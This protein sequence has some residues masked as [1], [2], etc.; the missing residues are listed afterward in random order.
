LARALASGGSSRCAQDP[1]GRAGPPIWTPRITALLRGGSVRLSRVGKLGHAFF[2]AAPLGPANGLCLHTYR[3]DGNP[4]VVFDADPYPVRLA[5]GPTSWPT[6]PGAFSIRTCGWGGGKGD[7][8]RWHVPPCHRE[9]TARDGGPR[10]TGSQHASPGLL[11]LD[12]RCRGSMW[13][14]RSTGRHAHSAALRRPILGRLRRPAPS[15]PRP[16]A[17]RP[18]SDPGLP[19]IGGQLAQHHRRPAFHTGP[20]LGRPRLR[21]S[22][23]GPGPRSADGRY[24]T[25]LARNCSAARATTRSASSR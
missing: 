22:R 1:V 19:R 12:R 25:C 5:G 13:Q 15:R 3:G 18:P 10:G 4:V 16:L 9:P 14:W 6:T 8:R 7:T 21:L 17:R 24:P 11:A 2:E 23:H 20:G